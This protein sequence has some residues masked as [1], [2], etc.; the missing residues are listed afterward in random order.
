MTNTLV[1]MTQSGH[2]VVENDTNDTLANTAAEPSII[3][4]L[5]DNYVLT[6]S[7]QLQGSSQAAQTSFLVHRAT[8]RAGLIM[9]CFLL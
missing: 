7:C 4:A 5:S 8:E 3:T 6:P 2:N 9:E 1:V